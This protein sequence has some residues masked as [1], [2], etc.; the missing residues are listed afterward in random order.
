M[1]CYIYSVRLIKVGGFYSFSVFPFWGVGRLAVEPMEQHISLA[2]HHEI[3]QPLP[4]RKIR[5]RNNNQLHDLEKEL[6]TYNMD[7][8]TR[9]TGQTKR[10]AEPSPEPA[11]Q[12]QSQPKAPNLKLITLRMSS[13]PIG[14]TK[15]ILSRI[16]EG[17]EPIRTSGIEDCLQAGAKQRRRTNIHSL[18]L[19]P[20]A[21][22][23]DADKFQV[24]TITFNEIPPELA[25]CV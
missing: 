19:A 17:L 6:L 16:L 11:V 12:P 18:S 21:S 20:A 8:L 13:I 3:H 14:I 15:V 7:N 4:T 10:P 5:N 23:F 22:S 25:D 24:A 1:L 2:P 9:S